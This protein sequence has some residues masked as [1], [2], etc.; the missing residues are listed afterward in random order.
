MTKPKFNRPVPHSRPWA[1]RLTPEILEYLMAPTKYGSSRLGAYVSLLQ[2][3]AETATSYKPMYGQTFDLEEG[4]LVIS[5]TDLADQW[6]WARETVRKFL[7]QLEAFKLL[8][9]KNLDRCSL[10]TMTMEWLDAGYKSVI[11]DVFPD[12][13]MPK[14]LS[15]KMDEWLSGDITDAEM[16]EASAEVASTF[17]NTDAFVLS[18]QL[19]ALLFSM[20]RQLVGRWSGNHVE[21]P[22]LPDAS[23]REL[24]GSLWNRCLSGNWLMWFSLLKEY[25]SGASPK[26]ADPKHSKESAAMTDGRA[27]LDSLFNHLKVGFARY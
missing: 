4:Q 9:K 26:P 8:V 7:D 10:L 15:D 21:L 23:T 17:E 19:D 16:A 22:L 13:Q 14:S 3:T 5:I 12:F 1:V 25:S 18:Y 20:I 6:N 11:P 24:L 27:I 2:S